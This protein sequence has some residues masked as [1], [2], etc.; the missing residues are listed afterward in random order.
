MICQ[1]CQTD[2]RDTAKFC[3]ECG[4][5]LE[6]RC[7]SCGEPVTAGSNFCDGCGARLGGSAPEP[8]PRRGRGDITAAVVTPPHLAAKILAARAALEDER[9]VVTVLFADLKGSTEL[10]STMDP[11]DARDLLD[12]VVKIMIE[13]VHAYEGTVTRVMGDGLMAL[14]GAPIS[15]EDHALRACYASLRMQERVRRHAVE[16]ARTKGWPIACRVGLNTGDVVVRSIGI[17]LHVDYTAQGMTTHLAA[18]MESTA[19]PGTIQITGATLGLVEG[20]VQATSLGPIEVKGFREPVEAFE[21]LGAVTSRTR[22]QVAAARG[23]TRF[24][25]RETHLTTLREAQ[26]LASASRG[27]VV[28]VVGEAG[29]G[30]SRLFW[31]FSHS[32]ET[33]GWLVL[34]SG[35]A[36]YA[37]ATAYLPVIGLL[38]GYFQISDGDDQPK[39]LEKVTGKLLSLDHDLDL[40]LDPILS[41]LDLEVDDPAWTQI[42]AAQRRARTLDAL[43]RLVIRECQIQP[44][45]LIFEDLHLVDTETQ[46]WLDR[47]MMSL[48]SARMLLLANYR[49]DFRHAWGNRP[50]LREIRIEALPPEGADAL[51]ESLLGPD[52]GLGPLKA[53]LVERTEGNPFFLEESVRTLVETRVLVGERGAYRAARPLADVQ[54]PASVQSL[55]AARIDRLSAEDKRLL[56]A[57]SVIGKDVP[58]PLLRSISDMDEDALLAGLGRLIEGEFVYEAALFPELEHT[59]KH[60]LTHQVAYG[61]LTNERRRNLHAR[62]VESIEQLHGER[63]DEHVDRLAS[64]ALRGALW[65]PAVRY[66]RQAGTRDADRWAHRDAVLAL[67][68]ALEALKHLPEEPEHIGARID[69]SL[70]LRNSLVVLGEFDRIF[71]QLQ[72]AQA[73]AERLGDERR[74]GRLHAALSNH[75]FWSIGD[76]DRATASGSQALAMG[77]ATGDLGLEV[78]SNF[79]LGQT[80]H[81]RGDYTA[82]LP[83]LDATVARLG[84]QAAH[85]RFG[86]GGLPAVFAHNI[87]ARCL[88]EQGRFADGL[89]RAEQGL[90][91]AVE[92]QHTYSEAFAHFGIGSVHLRQGYATR[93]L[94]ELERALT[95]ARQGNLALILLGVA[96]YVGVA[97]AHAG[98]AAE[99]VA[100]LE[101]TLARASSRIGQSLRLLA[102]GEVHLLRDDPDAAAAP[103]E[104]GLAMARAHNERGSEARGLFLEALL[105]L[106]RDPR[107]AR[108]G[109]AAAQALAEQLGMAP[110]VARAALGAA[111]AGSDAGAIEAAR[112]QFATLGMPPPGADPA[113]VYV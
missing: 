41:I 64:H 26:A 107:S 110:L 62:I 28:T 109:F 85:E 102:L 14:F 58:Y 27:Q 105:T 80:H 31:E 42:E 23:L 103:L 54:A 100:L 10:V 65:A 38:R 4:A 45:L 88:A 87:A 6:Q 19:R 82:S 9:K 93:S 51:L 63:L 20:F 74:L 83:F 55:L 59:F 46:A 24:V 67:D 96:P 43:T 71:A 36:S 37:R 8:A 17:D 34:E 53:L 57:A 101:E 78:T 75:Y 56:Q 48:V 1:A 91:I 39:I 3:R 33:A 95:M 111:C 22:L 99:G 32:P 104:K 66:L 16:M 98:R 81:A 49:P 44:V 106:R 84:A 40:V 50:Q 30:K 21:L 12:P 112:A 89:A 70:A 52:P 79:F 77:R 69:V 29:V 15:H 72:E 94:I 7:P 92:A 13:A 73:L 47:L 18:R 108:E 2:N 60:A 61:T 25:G 5:A 97:W 11:E 86:L 68:S 76:L 90:A 113:H 35:S